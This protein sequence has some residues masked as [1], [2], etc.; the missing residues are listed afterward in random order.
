MKSTTIVIP[1]YWGPPEK[2]SDV[3]EEI[4]F[5]HPTQLNNEGTL[6]RLLEGLLV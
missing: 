2:S 5:D 6:R 3:K 1:S 4:I